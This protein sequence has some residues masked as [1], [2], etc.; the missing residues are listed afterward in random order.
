M[1][2]LRGDATPAADIV[3]ATTAELMATNACDLPLGLRWHTART[4]IIGDAAHAASPAA[5]QGRTGN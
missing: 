3:A 2:L 4:L 5:G 1:P